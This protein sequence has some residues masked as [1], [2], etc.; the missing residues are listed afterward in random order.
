MNNEIAI[1]TKEDS[2]AEYLS[3]PKLEQYLERLLSWKF[4]QVPKEQIQNVF[5]RCVNQRLN[6][7]IENTVY[8]IPHDN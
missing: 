2:L 6:P 4:K 3:K 1:F 8:F 7:L 5:D